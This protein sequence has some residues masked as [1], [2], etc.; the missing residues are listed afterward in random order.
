MYQLA[1]DPLDFTRAT[2]EVALDGD[3]ARAP[4]YKVVSNPENVDISLPRLMVQKDRIGPAR[5]PA[6]DPMT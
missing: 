2:F 3:D 4:G 1:F 5:R 6:T